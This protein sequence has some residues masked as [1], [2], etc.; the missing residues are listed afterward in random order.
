M[1]RQAKSRKKETRKG[2]EQEG[3]RQE[4]K[5]RRATHPFA[6]RRPRERCLLKDQRREGG[7]VVQD[8]EVK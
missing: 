4:R 5:W 1:R 7:W 2:K 3:K 8:I 6:S